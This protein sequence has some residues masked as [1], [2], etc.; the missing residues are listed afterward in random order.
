MYVI[1]D[2]KN[3]PWFVIWYD[4]YPT[5][6]FSIPSPRLGDR[7][8]LDKNHFKSQTMGDP[9]FIVAI[10]FDLLTLKFHLLFRNFKIGHISLILSDKAFIFHMFVT[11]D[12]TFLLGFSFLT[13]WLWNLTM[14]TFWIWPLDICFS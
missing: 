13:L 9:I 4:F 12:K 14:A 5:R 6:V 7:I 10:I 2:K 11:C 8:T 3:L 1:C